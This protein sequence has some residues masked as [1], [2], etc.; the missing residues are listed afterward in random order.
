MREGESLWEHLRASQCFWKPLRACEN[1]WELMRSPEGLWRLWKLLRASESSW[2]LLRV[3]RASNRS[4]WKLLRFAIDSWELLRVTE[5]YL[6]CLGALWENQKSRLES[7]LNS[8][9]HGWKNYSA[10]EFPF[11]RR[12][13]SGNFYGFSYFSICYFSSSSVV[14]HLLKNLCLV[15][16][17]LLLHRKLKANIL[18][19][20]V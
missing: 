8:F 18:E 12:P 6:K 2:E 9:S 16:I 3:F 14:V 19:S 7:T 13:M 15:R 11:P 4:P 17:E 10:K 5:K 20:A 1:F